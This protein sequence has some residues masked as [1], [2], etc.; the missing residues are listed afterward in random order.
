MITSL[1]LVVV[2]VPLLGFILGGGLARALPSPVREK[3]TIV[4]TVAGISVACICAWI[5]FL[6]PKGG[7]L[8]RRNNRKY[9]TE[10][11]E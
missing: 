5:V 4:L 8:G 1:A 3:T 6:C 10:G 2:M 7:E 11:E 9:N